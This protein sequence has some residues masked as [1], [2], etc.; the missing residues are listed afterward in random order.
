MSVCLYVCVCPC[1]CICLN[2]LH[3]SDQRRID[4]ITTIIMMIVIT[5]TM[6]YVSTVTDRDEIPQCVCLVG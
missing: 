6:M 4:I 3:V 5:I 2:G 1:A